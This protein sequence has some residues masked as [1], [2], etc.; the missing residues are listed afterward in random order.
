[1]AVCRAVLARIY[2][3]KVAKATQP[4]YST[5]YE[6]NWEVKCARVQ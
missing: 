6:R 2:L 5:K 1:M 4:K 3:L